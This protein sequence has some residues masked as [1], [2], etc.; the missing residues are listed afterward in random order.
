MYFST[1]KILD[2]RNNSKTFKTI[3]KY[4]AQNTTSSFTIPTDILMDISEEKTAQSDHV[5]TAYFELKL[6]HLRRF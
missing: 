6:F 4:S 2:M 5:K 1:R 3:Q